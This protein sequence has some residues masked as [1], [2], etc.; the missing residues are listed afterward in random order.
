[1]KWA[2]DDIMYHTEVTNYERI[3]SVKSPP[4]EGC[5][6]HGLFLEGVAWS[7]DHQILVESEPKTLFVALPVL[8]VSASLKQDEMKNRRD[9]YG[10]HG[11]YECPC[12]KYRTRADR[13]Y[14]CMVT[15]EC[16]PEKNPAFWTLRGVG[17]LCNTD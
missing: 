14:I 5:Y 4:S 1:V 12:Y 16:T 17:L 11:P 3:E 8:M 13:Y 6:I 10:S 15:L 2:L 7:K 9:I